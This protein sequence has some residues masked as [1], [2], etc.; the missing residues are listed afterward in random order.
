[1]CWG[2]AEKKIYRLAIAGVMVLLAMLPLLITPP[3][4]GAAAVTG[5]WRVEQSQS[6]AVQ[7]GMINSSVVA[8]GRWMAWIEYATAGEA[9]GSDA[10]EHDTASARSIRVTDLV[11]GE[12]WLIGGQGYKRDLTAADGYLAWNQD[13][14]NGSEAGIYLYNLEQKKV[15][16]IFEQPSPRRPTITGELVVWDDQR[17]APLAPW[18]SSGITDLYAYSISEGKERPLVTD[19]GS[20]AAGP[21]AGN[22]LPYSQWPENILGE[23]EGVQ[24]GLY[25]LDLASGEKRQLV[26]GKKVTAG[27]LA[28]DGKRLAY[29]VMAD[30]NRSHLYVMDIRSGTERRITGQPAVIHEASLYK[31]LVVWSALKEENPNDADIYISDLITGG[32]SLLFSTTL[33]ETAP[34]IISD[35]RTSGGPAEKALLLWL[36]VDFTDLIDLAP[37][38]GLT[39]LPR[40]VL[41]SG[42]LTGGNLSDGFELTPAIPFRLVLT[43]GSRRG[44]TSPAGSGVLTLEAAPFL[45]GGRVMAPL[46]LIAE[47]LGAEVVWDATTE[48]VTVTGPG[49]SAV[50]LEVGKSSATINGRDV[51]LDT[52]PRVVA[53][54][55]FVPVR[56]L[57]EALGASVTWDGDSRRVIIEGTLP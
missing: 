52:P 56:F 8:T 5:S 17:N 50:R 47:G 21:A 4:A 14:R 27:V 20:Q 35:P 43:I 49:R 16:R 9:I 1:M 7:G 53:G 29:K 22:L 3:V 55:T 15:T 39:R 12:T 38:S 18:G 44:E 11:S 36:A 10:R 33:L 30:A 2:K 57:A 24:V 31:N 46:R 23:H 32:T 42:T 51:Y 45:E 48:T 28:F 37:G 13:P 41:C 54:S 6:F 26:G 19:P 34:L 25:L 40:S